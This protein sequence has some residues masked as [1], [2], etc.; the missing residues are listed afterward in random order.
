MARHLAVRVAQGG[1]VEGR[2]D[3]LALAL[4]GLSRALRVTPAATTS[5]SAAV[6]S[7]VSSG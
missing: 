6:N 1:G 2:G 5:R 7:R 3:H 4:L